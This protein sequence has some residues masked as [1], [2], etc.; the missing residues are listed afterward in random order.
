MKK[1]LLSVLLVATMVLSMTA[2]GNNTANSSDATATPAATEAA[3]DT[4]A[5]VAPVA[6]EAA[7]GEVTT[8][9]VWSNNRHDQDYMTAMVEAFNAR[10]TGVQ[11]NYTVMAD[12]WQNSVQLAYQANTAPDVIT[13]SASDGMKLSD[14]VNSGMFVSLNDYITADTQFQTVTD[15]YN[16]LYEGLNAIG[17]SIYWVPNGVRSGTRIEYNI[18]LIQAAGYTAIPSTLGELVTLCK[19]VTTAGNGDTYGVAFTSSG[20]FGRW[21]DGVGEMSGNTHGGYDYVNGVYDF[22]SWKALLE[23][24]AQL[25][26]DGSVLPGSETQGVDNSRALFAEGSFAVWGNASQEAGVFTKQF[27][28]A[29]EWGVAELPTLT[30]EVTGALSCTPNFAW[31][32][33]SSCEN[34]DAAWQVISYF[35]SEEF[36][37]GY[38]EGG[39][40]APISTYMAGVIDSTVVGRLADFALTEYEDVYPTTPSITLEGDDYPTVFFQVIMGNINVDDAIAD[41]NTRYNDALTRGLEAGS[42]TRL[43]ISDFDPLNPSSGTCTYLTE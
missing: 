18:G 26:T 42:C 22:T 17:D 12:D 40:S 19:D 34:K 35:S 31:T 32:M 1:K 6:T 41:L 30:G 15:C 24:A 37:K 7:S 8:I 21:L 20:P 2:C 27:P 33:L 14:Y 16:H 25:Y 28:C 11:I 36:L 38:F 9:E 5:T 39:Y 23:T 29:F 3:T 13:I 10:H 43:V 4:T